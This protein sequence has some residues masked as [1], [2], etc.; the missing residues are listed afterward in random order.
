M[1]YLNEIGRINQKP[2]VIIDSLRDEI[3]LTFSVNNIERIIS[4]A[5]HFD[6]TR[7]PFDRIIVADASVGNSR[8]ISK[9]KKITDNYNKTIW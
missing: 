4:Q 3:G 9:D 1:K 5:I 6:F 2:D 7:D 8:L